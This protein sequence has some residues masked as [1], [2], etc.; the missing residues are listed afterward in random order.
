[1]MRRPHIDGPPAAMRRRCRVAYAMRRTDYC[2]V[3]SGDIIVL[4]QETGEVVFCGWA[5]EEG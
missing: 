4:A 5:N 1:M 3:A 2:M